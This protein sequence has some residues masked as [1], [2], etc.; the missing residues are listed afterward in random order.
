MCHSDQSIRYDLV[1]VA[2]PE[3]LLTPPEIGF[4]KREFDADSY[5]AELRAMT[6]DELLREGKMLHQLVYPRT[7]LPYVGVFE[8]KLV[9]TRE[10]RRR[11]GIKANKKRA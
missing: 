9:V 1:P 6:D 5:R 3:G 8:L 4:I 2:H 7:V 11:V 10:Y